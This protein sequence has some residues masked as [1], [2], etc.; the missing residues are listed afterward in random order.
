VVFNY[1]LKNEYEKI[2]KETL[3]RKDKIDI[4]NTL[5]RVKDSVEC[6]IESTVAW[7]LS[8]KCLK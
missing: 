6:K 3:D 2:F 7:V 4:N 8:D 1:W 5:A